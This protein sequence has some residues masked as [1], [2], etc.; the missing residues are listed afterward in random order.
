MSSSPRTRPSPGTVTAVSAVVLVLAIAVAAIALGFDPLG[1]GQGFV[2]GLYPPV[3]VTEE[4]AQIRD[5][6]TIV[7]LIAAAIF[8][9]R[10]GPDHLV[11]HPLPAQ[12]GRRHAAAR[13]PTA[14]TWPRRSGRSSRR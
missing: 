13:R 9:A 4:G 3:A 2:T 5:L 6:Y 14:T 12:A 7:F 10:R 11:G 8:F 1:V